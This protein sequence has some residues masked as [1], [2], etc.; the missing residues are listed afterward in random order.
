MWHE[1][2]KTPKFWLITPVM[3]VLALFIACGG[4]APPEPVVVEKEVVREVIKE[5]PVEKIVVATPTPAPKPPAIEKPEGHLRIAYASLGT[6]AIYPKGSNINAGGKDVQTTMYDVI[7]GSNGQGALSK[8]T[9]LAKDWSMTPDAAHHT[10]HLRKG[11]KF[12]N[13]EE[14]T[15]EDA[16]F[17]IQEVMEEDSQAGFNREI[18]PVLESLEVPDPYT[19]VI[20]C[21]QVCLFAPWIFSEYEGPT[22]W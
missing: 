4:S 19:L 20:N 11:V 13:G 3:L 9:G 1:W 17:S 21:T 12:H 2:L 18:K 22:G 16:K 7:I 14:V 5:V 15:A 10:F 8:E 6:D